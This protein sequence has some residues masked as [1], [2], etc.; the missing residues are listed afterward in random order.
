MMS[1]RSLIG[2]SLG[3]VMLVMVPVQS[4]AMVHVISDIMQKISVYADYIQ[5]AKA[6]KTGIETYKQMQDTYAT[7]GELKK[8][9]GKLLKSIQNGLKDEAI[10]FG[11]TYVSDVLK[12]KGL[13]KVQD[14]ATKLQA[15]VRDKMVSA[16]K[17]ATLAEAKERSVMRFAAKADAAA[18]SAATAL[19]YLSES[20]KAQAEKLEPAKSTIEEKET[21]K[22]KVDGTNE[23]LVAILREL[24]EGNRLT[25]TQLRLMS[26]SELAEMPVFKEDQS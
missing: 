24:M 14:D 22:D 25:A 1:K 21:L 12:K 8:A 20:T 26:A 3:A 18:D 11:K 13:D 10:K 9:K 23:V 16:D 17:K 19:A 5:M 15:F 6:L 4:H 2:A 7:I